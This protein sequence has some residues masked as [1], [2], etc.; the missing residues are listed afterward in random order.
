VRITKT[1]TSISLNIIRKALE[2]IP[3]SIIIID[4]G[5]KET[6]IL[7]KDDKIKFE[8][9]LI[10]LTK[11]LLRYNL[12]TKTILTLGLPIFKIGKENISSLKTT[13]ILLND[14]KLYEQIPPVLFDISN[15][16]KIVPKVFDFDPIG[17]KERDEL[18]LHLYS[19]SKIFTKNITIVRESLNPIR[20]MAKE[21]NILQILPLKKEMFEKRYL[22]FFNTDSE[23][24]SYDSYKFNQIL[25]PVIEN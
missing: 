7:L 6:S 2:R 8:I 4:Y 14:N 24:L 11:S 21:Q 25:I 23:L 9:G 16:L 17:D 22:N 19:L 15:Q 12:L 3:N 1:T 20:R 13:L 10:I 18:I 5:N